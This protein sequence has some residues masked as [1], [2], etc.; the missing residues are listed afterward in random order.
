MSWL[1]ISIAL[2]VISVIEAASVNYIKLLGV[3]P[4]LTL[5]GVLYFSLNSSKERGAACG[6]IGGILKMA[7]SGLNPVI[8][9][10]YTSIGFLA[11][12]YKEMLYKQL[13]SARM[14]VAFAAVIYSNIIY[15][16]LISSLGFPYYKTIFF[17]SLPSAI[18]T[19]VLAPLMFMAL[20]S[21]TPPREVE[22]REIIFKKRVFEGRRPQ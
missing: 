11:G 13:T 2:V 16:F 10:I 18:Y 22:Y 19:A 1:S 4:E 9:I 3:G 6:L 5:L 20:D 12:M 17:V 7:F 14:I 15:G 8:L 21:V